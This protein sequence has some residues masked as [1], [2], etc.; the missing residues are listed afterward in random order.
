MNYG[1][2]WDYFG[3]VGEQNHQFSLFDVKSQGLEQVGA[4]GGPSTLYPKDWNNFAPRLSIVDDL[5][6]NGK[7]VL[8]AGYGIFYDGASQDFF[9][10]NQPWNTCPAEAGPAFNN[11][12]FAGPGCGGPSNSVLPVV[13]D[14]TNGYAIGT[15]IFSNYTTTSAFTVAQNLSTPIYQSYNLNIESQVSRRVAVQLGYVGTQGRHLFRFRDLNQFNNV[16]GSIDSCGNGQ[17]IGYGQQC[18]PNYYYVNQIETSASSTYNSLQGSLKIQN[19]HGLS[20]T[21]NY[22]WAHSIDNASDGLDFVPNAAQPD[23]SFNPSGERASSNFDVRHRVQ[24]YWTY[25]LPQYKA[26][27]WLTNG[28]ALDGMFN[29][30]TGQPYG[31]NYIYE[32]D[33]NGTGE[34]FGRPDI[35]GNPHAGAHGTN[36]LNLAAFA[37]PCTVD[38]SED[39]I[40]GTQHPGSEGRNAFNAPNYANF[41]LSLTKTSHISEQLTMQLRADIFNI[42]NHPNMSNPLLPGFGIDAFVDGGHRVGDRLVAG[43]DPSGTTNGVVNGPQ[44]VQTTATPDVGSG[45]PYLG[46][47]G[48]R[49]VQLAVRFTF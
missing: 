39:C 14:G 49:T 3:V 29:F 22:T 1:I 41:D 38:A 25:N 33:Y 18:F 46:G 16:A 42:L 4:N 31:V 5:L 30:A 47:G 45:N 9:V 7:V 21:L 28:W 20:S 40:S 2:R 6:G 27:K 13:P 43:L 15:S 23:N 19:W 35:I 34:Y 44:F 8:R 24:W 36:L 26:A 12:A 10:G 37:A 11:I 32:A 48:P 17:S